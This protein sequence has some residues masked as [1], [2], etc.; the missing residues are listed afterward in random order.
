MS[1]ASVNYL[2]PEVPEMLRCTAQFQQAE[3]KAMALG[4]QSSWGKS[5]AKVQKEGS[6]GHWARDNTIVPC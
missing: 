6:K 4:E 1:Q 3:A 5:E 2:T